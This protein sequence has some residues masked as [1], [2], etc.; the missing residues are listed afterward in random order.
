MKTTVLTVE[1]ITY[2]LKAR[3]LL[4]RDGISAK[5]IKAD[6]D[7][8]AQGCTYGIEIPAKDFYSAASILR[9]A[10]IYYKIY[11]K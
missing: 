11:E 6:A 5:L 10:E 9:S 3:K 1:S 7:L 4:S 8:A 2:A